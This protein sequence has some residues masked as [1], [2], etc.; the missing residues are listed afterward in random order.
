MGMKGETRISKE[1]FLEEIRGILVCSCRIK[2]LLED[3]SLDMALNNGR[4]KLSIS[5]MAEL[6]VCLEERYEIQ[7][8]ER[9][10]LYKLFDKLSNLY[11]C[12]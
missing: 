3:I 5:Q 9:M 1:S 12:V 4:H 8:D 6:L 10:E 7:F 11:E 2:W